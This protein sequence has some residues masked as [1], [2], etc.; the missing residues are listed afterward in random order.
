M[1]PCI[2]YQYLKNQH[3]AAGQWI[4]ITALLDIG[5]PPSY[6][7]EYILCHV[8]RRSSDVYLC[9]RLHIKMLCSWWWVQEAP[10]TCRVVK[11][12]SNKNSL[13]SCIVYVLMFRGS[14]LYHDW[15]YVRLQKTRISIFNISRKPFHTFCWNLIWE[16]FIWTYRAVLT[17]RDCYVTKPS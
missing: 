17:L 15:T 7:A 10:E 1:V 6:V 3:D 8:G 4:F 2:T 14:R 9:Q 11:K 5:R 13:P 12:C 16:R